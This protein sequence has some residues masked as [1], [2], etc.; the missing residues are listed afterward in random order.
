MTEIVSV[1]AIHL[2]K[3]GLTT[4]VK[5]SFFSSIQTIQFIHKTTTSLKKM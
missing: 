1:M 3:E 2:K 4:A 5:P